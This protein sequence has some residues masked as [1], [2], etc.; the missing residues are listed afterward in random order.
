METN[1]I[2]RLI[3]AIIVGYGLLILAFWLFGRNKNKK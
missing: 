1:L 3:A 2:L